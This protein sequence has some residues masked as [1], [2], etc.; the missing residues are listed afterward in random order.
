MVQKVRMDA[1]KNIIV[2]NLE[3]KEEKILRFNLLVNVY[4]TKKIIAE[5]F[6]LSLNKF[7]LII[8]EEEVV[9]YKSYFEPLGEVEKKG[10]ILLKYRPDTASTTKL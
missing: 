1:G 5:K 7:D 6:N 2:K 10:K 3:N 8:N 4:G 9:G